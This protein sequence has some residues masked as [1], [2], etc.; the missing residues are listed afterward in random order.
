MKYTAELEKAA[1]LCIE[2]QI[3]YLYFITQKPN[4]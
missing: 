1:V 2:L 4:I 3:L